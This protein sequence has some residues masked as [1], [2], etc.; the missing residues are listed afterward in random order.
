VEKYN[1]KIKPVS[2]FFLVAEIADE[3]DMIIIS[4]ND[5]CLIH[6]FP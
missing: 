2:L 6:S 1:I 4:R 3:K 5:D